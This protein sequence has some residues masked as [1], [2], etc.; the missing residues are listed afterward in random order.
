MITNENT[1]S[2]VPTLHVVRNYERNVYDKLFLFSI[3]YN[4]TYDKGTKSTSNFKRHTST[5]II[6][7]YY[8]TISL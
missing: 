1:I 2:L 8:A 4:Y 6:V 5:N 3:S 7:N